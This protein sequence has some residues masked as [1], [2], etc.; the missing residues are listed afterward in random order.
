MDS[1][2]EIKFDECSGGIA[3]LKNKN[4]EFSMN[5]VEGSAVWGTVKDSKLLFFELTDAGMRAKF[6]HRKFKVSVER[7]IKDNKLIESYTFINNSAVSVSAGRGE[8]GIYTTFNDSY[9]SAEI[10][11]TQRCNTHIWCGENT[12]WVNALKMGASD[13]NL[14]LVLTK[15]SIDCYSVERDTDKASNDRGDFI[16]HPQAFSLAP[17]ESR[18]VEWEIFFHNGTD[19]FNKKLSEYDVIIPEAEHYTV[20]E[21]EQ[22]EILKYVIDTFIIEGEKSLNKKMYAFI[23]YFI[24]LSH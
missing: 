5:W 22:I 17:G 11:M 18:V 12:T 19:D 4:D 9:D 8:I 24:I 7:I 23:F 16:L 14:G 20:F 1:V 2:F 10:C 13:I 3:S 21:N 15:G 6:S